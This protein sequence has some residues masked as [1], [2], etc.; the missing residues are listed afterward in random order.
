MRIHYYGALLLLFLNTGALADTPSTD[1]RHVHLMHLD[2]FRSD[3]FQALLEGGHLPHFSFLLSRGRLSLTNS[4]VDKSETMK[5][6]QSYLTSKLDTS[7]VGWWQFNRTDLLFKNYWIDLA[8]MIDYAIGTKFPLTP[9]LYDYITAQGNTVMAGFSL[10]R[11]GVPFE[12]YARAYVEGIDAALSSHKYLDQAHATMSET[13]TIYE[14]LALRAKTHNDLPVF[15][16]SLL[17]PADEFCHLLGVVDEHHKQEEFCYERDGK[18]ADPT[19]EQL[20]ILLDQDRNAKPPLFKTLP[21][22]T[23]PVEWERKQ[24]NIVPWPWS[25]KWWRSKKVCIPTPLLTYAAYDQ[26]HEEN[27]HRWMEPVFKEARVEPKYALGMIFVDIELGRLINSMRTIYFT[28]Q[29][30]IKIDPSRGNSILRYLS[31]ETDSLFAHTTFIFTGDHGMT[32]TPK[33]TDPMTEASKQAAEHKRHS[34]SRNETFLEYLNRNLGL[35]SVRPS[36]GLSG[37]VK[38]DGSP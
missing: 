16:T 1:F 20:F 38:A 7:V 22:F 33:M 3:L 25:K 17:A 6:I 31:S 14:R 2:G 4:T 24:E 35:S 10:H 28:P 37:A 12:N 11:R 21:Y 26:K 23:K 29:G 18:T 15:T 36:V 32:H 34:D 8:D 27:N 9:N 13:I 19:V 5:V 30:T